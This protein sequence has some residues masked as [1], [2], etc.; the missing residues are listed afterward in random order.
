M[1]TI[2]ITRR[3][4]FLQCPQRGRG[5]WEPSFSHRE[6]IYLPLTISLFPNYSATQLLEFQEILRQDCQ[7]SQ[8][9]VCKESRR[10][11]SPP[12]K[13]NIQMAI[14]MAFQMAKW[15]LK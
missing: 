8:A 6:I 5:C 3:R 7:R 12:S 13:L 9:G 14:Q 15:I 4:G 1:S 10:P 2:K 11:A